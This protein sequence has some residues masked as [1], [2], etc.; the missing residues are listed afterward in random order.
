M[1]DLHTH[2]LP[3]MDDGAKDVQQS[4]TLLQMEKQ[5]G[6]DTVV[7]TPHFYRQKEPVERFL[8]RRNKAMEA[9]QAA[10]PLD[11]PKLI[12]GAEVA[13]YPTILQE[14]DLDKLCLGNSGYI[15][16]ELPNAAWGK[17][18]VEQIQNFAKNSGLKPILAHI[19]RY[20]PLQRPKQVAQLLNL[21]LPMQMST[22]ALVRLLSR[23]RML[24]FLAQGKWYLGSD[25]HNTVKRKP[26]MDRAVQYLK[27][28][29]ADADIETMI[30]WDEQ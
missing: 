1:T 21:G 23:K 11:S 16:L 4:L 19:E 17:Y 12:L 29:L 14:K 3:G 26:S 9:L 13:W 22:D 30:N 2:I 25:C 24:K 7:L 15:L 18:L 6:V 8:A 20:L 27:K 10:L 5:Q 28:H